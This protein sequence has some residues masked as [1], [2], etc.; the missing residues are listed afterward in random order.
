MPT[1]EFAPAELFGKLYTIAGAILC[2]DDQTA[3]DLSTALLASL[4]KADKGRTFYPQYTGTDHGASLASLA[5]LIR[6]G[7]GD[8][9]RRLIDRLVRDWSRRSLW[10]AAAVERKAQRIARIADSARRLSQ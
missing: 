2:N 1:N 8:A 10:D 5:G 3:L 9:A 6:A 4:S 7:R